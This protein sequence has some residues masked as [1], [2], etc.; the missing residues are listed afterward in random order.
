MTRK[1]LT[2]TAYSP[3]SDDQALGYDAWPRDQD[4]VGAYTADHIVILQRGILDAR[5]WRAGLHRQGMGCQ[6]VR[7]SEEEHD[8]WRKQFNH[9]RRS[10]RK[11]RSCTTRSPGGLL[12]AFLSV[13]LLTTYRTKRTPVTTT[14]FT[15]RNLCLVAG[16]YIED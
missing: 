5:Q 6:N 15:P 16:T 10:V 3:G 11:V 14:M 9:R 1:T 8:E 7:W 13:D 2:I 12:I 4:H